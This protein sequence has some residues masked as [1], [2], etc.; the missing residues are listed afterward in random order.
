MKVDILNPSPGPTPSKLS[1]VLIWQ[2]NSPQIALDNWS[3]EGNSNLWQGTYLLGNSSLLFGARSKPLQGHWLLKLWLLALLLFKAT[4][5]WALVVGFCCLFYRWSDNYCC[6]S[7]QHKPF[8]Y[9]LAMNYICN[10]ALPGA[11]HC[12]S[13]PW[14]D[15]GLWVCTMPAIQGAWKHAKLLHCLPSPSSLVASNQMEA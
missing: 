15:R 11:A 13:E 9:I 2:P 8:P 12:K 1:W 5:D 6:L 7:S 4:E 10:Q 3:I 14:S